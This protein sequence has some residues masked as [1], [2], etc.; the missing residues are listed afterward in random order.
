MTSRGAARSSH[1]C[2]G[3]N[4]DNPA[5]MIDM[6]TILI[7]AHQTAVYLKFLFSKIS[8]DA[9]SRIPT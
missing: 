1:L 9:E 2:K 6:K 3:Y 7:V 8:A 5:M 4:K